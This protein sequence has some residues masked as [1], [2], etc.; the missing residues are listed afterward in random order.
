MKKIILLA[1]VSLFLSIGSISG[2]SKGS[3]ND[4]ALIEEKI[5]NWNKALQAKDYKLAAQDYSDDA[6]WTN[7]FGMKRKG[8]LEIEKVL[9]EVFANPLRKDFC[10]LSDAFSNLFLV[11]C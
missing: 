6:D 5:E 9:A 8:R 10:E 11:K 3:K 4:Q 1:F 2:Q 7:A